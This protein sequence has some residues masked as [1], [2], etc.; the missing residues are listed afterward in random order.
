MGHRRRKSILVFF[1][2]TMAIIFSVIFIFN[3]IVIKSLFLE[4]QEIANTKK[5]LGFSEDIFE[6]VRSHGYERG[7]VNV[8]LN[9]KG[10]SENISDSI[11]FIEKH[12]KIG[13]DQLVKVLKNISE[14]YLFYDEKTFNK[15]VELNKHTENYQEIYGKQFELSFSDRDKTFDDLWFN[16]MSSKI[17]YLNVLIFSIKEKNKIDSDLKHFIDIVYVLSMLRDNAGPV[18]SYLKAATFNRESLNYSRIEELNNRKKIVRNLLDHLIIIGDG[19]LKPSILDNIEKFDLLYFNKIIVTGDQIIQDKDSE[20]LND[21]D[22]KEYLKNGVKALEQLQVLT[23]DI[24]NETNIRFDSK[25]YKQR[26][27]IVICIFLSIF[28]TIFILLSL[29]TIYKKIYNRIIFASK[30][31]NKISL[32]DLD[33][34]MNG[35]AI[36]DE[37]GDIEKGLIIFKE[38][39]IE[40]NNKNRMLRE[41]SQIDSMTGLLNHKTILEKIEIL[42]RECCRYN[43]SYCLMMIDID[44]FKNIN[45][46]YGH[47]V[48]DEVIQEVAE[49]LINS[50]R[51]TDFVGRY[52]GEEF[53]IAFSHLNTKMAEEVAEKLRVKVENTSFSSK[54]LKLTVSIGA[55]EFSPDLSVI[56]LVAIADQALYAAKDSGRNCIKFLS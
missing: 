25:I 54:H 1:A 53:L 7:R 6:V 51:N 41:L 21:N 14:S 29:F 33:I 38:K 22:V 43:K 9:F 2:T 12:K 39:L 55:S 46:S 44:F 37:I 36:N 56:E 18:V 15:I 47:L 8:V 26:I 42:H 27:K 52:G 28:I 20:F 3:S 13:N 35:K 5:V 45:D 32:N 19:H 16:H 48:G 4:Y 17:E 10:K 49:L 23:E 11:A 30:T 40:L 31:I 34:E 24:V 50:V